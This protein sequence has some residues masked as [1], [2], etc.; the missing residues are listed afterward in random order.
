MSTLLSQSENQIK[1]AID[2]VDRVTKLYLESDQNYIG[3]K[4]MYES[5]RQEYGD[6]KKVFSTQMSKLESRIECLTDSAQSMSEKFEKEMI[7]KLDLR[8]RVQEYECELSLN[9]ATLEDLVLKLQVSNEYRQS[10]ID[11][12]SKVKAAFEQM[13]VQLDEATNNG[14]HL[15]EQLQ[16][17]LNE[18]QQLRELSVEVNANVTELTA[19]NQKLHMELTQ[20]CGHQVLEFLCRELR[21]FLSFRHVRNLKTCLLH[22]LIFSFFSE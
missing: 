15:Q 16:I 18:S 14:L 12:L 19:Q 11:E 7:E 13:T 2:E 1:I 4:E 8:S 5:L 9:K 17:S 10:S 22:V 3:T 20:L 6:A 21:S